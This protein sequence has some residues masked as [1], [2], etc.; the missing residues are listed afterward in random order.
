MER[1]EH[2][3]GSSCKTNLVA[4]PT[5]KRSSS[6]RAYYVEYG[7]NDTILKTMILSFP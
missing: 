2:S 4:S 3:C 6:R 5:P 1:T 7:C